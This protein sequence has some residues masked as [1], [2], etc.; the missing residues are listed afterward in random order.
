MSSA[1]FT[2][3]GC[4]NYFNNL[5]VS[6]WDNLIIPASLNKETL[7]D[8]ILL[9]GGEFEVQYGSP[10]FIRFAIGSWS[11]KWAPTMQRWVD[12]LAIEYNPLENYDRIEDWT[13]NT[14]R[15]DAASSIESQNRTLGRKEEVS[16][17]DSESSSENRSDS[18]SENISEA[19]SESNTNH[20]EENASYSQSDAKNSSVNGENITDRDAFQ[21]HPITHTVER[22][23]YDSN[24]YEPVTK[25]TDAGKW[26]DES[27]QDTNESSATSSDSAS[28]SDITSSGESSRA[29]TSDVIGNGTLSSNKEASHAGSTDTTEND[30]IIHNS[31][32][33]SAMNN[34]AIHSGRVHGNIGVT[35]SQQM[36]QQELDLGYWN[37]YE[38]ITEL[39]LQEFTIPVYA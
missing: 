18:R 15:S 38:K 20:S 37:I 33:S 30:D 36:L 3:I 1:K 10:D 25:E 32:S 9:R 27:S 16:H 34:E 8:N 7:T 31:D 12:A 23:A 28:E 11:K 13:D 26:K 6:L 14:N 21:G 17:A 35:T 39:F 5:G 2:L 4:N 24:S 22:S 19:S 29:S